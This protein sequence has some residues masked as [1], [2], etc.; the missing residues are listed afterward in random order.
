MNR[1]RL[2]AVE[3]EFS[4]SYAGDGGKIPLKHSNGNLFNKKAS[5][6]NALLAFFSFTQSSVM[7]SQKV[8]P[9]CS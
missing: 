3:K 6:I 2:A 1:M 4:D 9:D 5:K 7:N 8:L